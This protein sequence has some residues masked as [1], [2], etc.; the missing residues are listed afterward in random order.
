MSDAEEFALVSGRLVKRIDVLETELAQKKRLVNELCKEY[1]HSP[2][3]PDVEQPKV[4]SL[5]TLSR[6]QFYGRPMATVV[7][8]YLEMRGPSN[9]GGRGAASV[10]EIYDALSTGGFKFETKDE[11][12][13]KRVLRIALS[14][15]SVTFHKVGN[16]YGLLEWYPNVKPTRQLREELPE[17]AGEEES[18]PEEATAE[19]PIM[20]EH[21]KAA[22]EQ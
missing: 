18:E 2:R 5:G 4:A 15:N 21:K 22:T 20:I 3:Y 16:N 13:A 14:K 12:N 19:E 6:D 1:G 9:R 11:A 10:N 17:G 8:E 7:R